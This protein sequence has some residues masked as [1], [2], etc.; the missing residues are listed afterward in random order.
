MND[1]TY[2]LNGRDQAAY[3]RG[4]AHLAPLP[5]AVFLDLRSGEGN[6]LPTVASLA[7][8]EEDHPLRTESRCR[9]YPRHCSC[10]SEALVVEA[11]PAL[12]TSWAL[13]SLRV[14]K[15]YVVIRT[16]SDPAG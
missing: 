3:D 10:P 13:S 2:P 7:V 6:Q 9:A 1:R 8:P 14:H 16:N 4:N 11:A 15:S 5:G 12:L